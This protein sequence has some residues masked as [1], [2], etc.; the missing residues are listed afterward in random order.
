MFTAERAQLSYDFGLA[1]RLVRQYIPEPERKD[2]LKTVRQINGVTTYLSQMACGEVRHVEAV[3]YAVGIAGMDVVTDYRQETLSDGVVVDALDGDWAYPELEALHAAAE[4][5][6]GP[7]FRDAVLSLAKWQDESLKQFGEL[8]PDELEGITYGKGGFSALGHLHAMKERPSP[9]ENK[10]IRNFGYVMQLLD[11]YL[12]Q[13]GDDAAGISTL[14]TSGEY[15]RSSLCYEIGKL[16]RWC[17]DVWGETPALGRFFRICRLHA[18]LGDVENN[19]L[20]PVK[21]A[22]PFYL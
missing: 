13:P 17:E 4:F 22:V 20:I 9:E 11:D 5:A 16:R 2:S 1:P 8:S 10:L 21:R 7:K 6:K 14:F 19:T 12:D 15:D 3:Y 18:R